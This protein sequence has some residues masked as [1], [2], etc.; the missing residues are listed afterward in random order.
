MLE[1]KVVHGSYSNWRTITV[2]SAIGNIPA[3][4]YAISA[5]D[6]TL[7]TVTF[8]V[9]ASDGSGAVTATAAFYPHRIAGSTT[10]AREF[11]T[12]D[13]A[14]IS[15]ASDGSVISGLR[16]RDFFQDHW[17]SFKSLS[18][19][20]AG[21]GGPSGAANEGNPIST[22]GDFTVQEPIENA[23]TLSGT[24]RTDTKTKPKALG[25]FVYKWGRNYVA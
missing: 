14:I 4:D 3:A 13:R 24:P 10:T 19:V 8:A 21:T 11:E 15:E 25:A 12:S 2:G 16:H 7:R 6:T 18:R 1:D 5:I 22:F 9:T 23:D 17:H 20:N